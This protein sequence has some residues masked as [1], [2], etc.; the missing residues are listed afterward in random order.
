MEAGPSA[1]TAYF[2]N[3]PVAGAPGVSSSLPLPFQD[4]S[5]P[6]SRSLWQKGQK[7]LEGLTGTITT[8]GHCPA[9]WPEAATAPPNPKGAGCGAPH[10]P[11]GGGAGGACGLHGWPCGPGPPEL[12]G[13]WSI[14]RAP[15]MH[16]PHKSANEAPPWAPLSV[17]GTAAQRRDASASGPKPHTGQGRSGGR[18]P[19]LLSGGPAGRLH[20]PE[21]D[22]KAQVCSVTPSTLPVS[23]AS[24]RVFPGRCGWLH[25]QLS[26]GNGR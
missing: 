6:T 17:K 5:S 9:C 14:A 10:V 4:P 18:N 26:G 12:D 16:S 19:G 1:H 24:C 3:L 25:P 21:E 2:L 22:L 7:P 20:Y 11:R 13:V 23:P 15:T 8:P